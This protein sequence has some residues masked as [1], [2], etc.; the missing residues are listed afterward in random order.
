MVEM[1][2]KVRELTDENP[3]IN[4]HSGLQSDVANAVDDGLK[5]ASFSG[6]DWAQTRE[7]IGGLAEIAID[8]TNKKIEE[9]FS[10]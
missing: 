1:W 10:N 3:V 5:Q 7:S 2:Y 6:T 4:I 9:G 8:E